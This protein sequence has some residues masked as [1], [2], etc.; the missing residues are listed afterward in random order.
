[1]ANNNKLF[2]SLKNGLHRA[3]SEPPKFSAL[4]M[5][6]TKAQMLKMDLKRPRLI[7]YDAITK[8][9]YDQGDSTKIKKD[10]WSKFNSMNFKKDM[11][12][13][14]LQYYIPIGGEVAMLNEAEKSAQETDRSKR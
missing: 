9:F 2:N 3:N 4:V 12:L 14:D 7:W 5:G 11:P 13:N 10:D 1:M 6:F 8:K